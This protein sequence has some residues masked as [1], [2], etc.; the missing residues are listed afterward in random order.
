MGRFTGHRADQNKMARW[1]FSL[2]LVDGA[3]GV[4]GRFAQPVMANV[5]VCDKGMKRGE[6][7]SWISKGR[8]APP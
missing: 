8:R 6:Q 3:G 1:L 2:S 4:S 5:A 7:A